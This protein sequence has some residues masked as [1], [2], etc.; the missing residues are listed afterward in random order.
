MTVK[1]FED[2]TVDELYD[3]LKLRVDVFV[4]EQ[5]CPYHEID[6]KDRCGYH[7]FLHDE[8]GIHAYLRVLQPGVSFKESSIG[9]V[10]SNPAKRRMGLG[11]TILQEGI[12]IAKE[13]MDTPGIRIEAQVYARSFYEAQGFVQSSDEFSEDGIPHI[14]MYL[15]FASSQS[16][17]SIK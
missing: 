17:D 1:E 13:K 11:T 14:E 6:G 16:I 4:V 15:D 10:I 8:E 12:R 9:R 5:N 2:L 7:V 3:I